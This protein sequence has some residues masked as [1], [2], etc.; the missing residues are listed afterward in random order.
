MAMVDLFP[1]NPEYKRLKAYI[2]PFHERWLFWA[3]AVLG[4]LLLAWI[5]VGGLLFLAR[6]ITRLRGKDGRPILPLLL[7]LVIACIIVPLIG[8]LLTNEGV[9]YFGLG[10]A[11]PLLAWVP[12]ILIG[13]VSFFA[14]TS[15]KVSRPRLIAASL[16][17]LP[18][19]ALLGYW[20][21]LLP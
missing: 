5:P 21:M 1:P 7:S 13:L 16:M 14:W 9:Y 17:L 11:M 2:T 19:F 18:L 12:S 3:L 10:N 8:V 4:G 6:L 15:R 20:G